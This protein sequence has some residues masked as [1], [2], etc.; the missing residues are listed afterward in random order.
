MSVNRFAFNFVGI[1][2]AGVCLFAALSTVFVVL[3]GFSPDKRG[4]WHFLIVIEATTAL[5]VGGGGIANLI[6]GR[7]L[8]RWPT[9]IM[10][11]GYCVSVWLVPLALWGIVSLLVERKCRPNESGNRQYNGSCETRDGTPVSPSV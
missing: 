2:I 9:G 11:A 3:P 5:T 8:A 4:F 1:L 7:R 10:I 6:K